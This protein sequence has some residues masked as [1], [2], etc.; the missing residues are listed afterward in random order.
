MLVLHLL[1]VCSEDDSASGAVQGRSPPMKTI[2]TPASRPF[3]V[4]MVVLPEDID[5]QGIANNVAVVAWMNRVA[6]AHSTALGWDIAR[7]RREGAWFVVR[8]HEI[9]YLRSAALGDRLELRTW[10][11]FMKAA[12]A[13]RG[14]EIVRDDG[15]VI[16]RGLNVW[17][18]VDAATGRPRRMSEDMLRAF[19]PEDYR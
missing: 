1:N 13:Q 11:Q 7:Y 15:A 3:T 16:A 8:R 2:W 6:I 9:D 17:A 19:D 10:P 5:G 4:P 18:Y 14:H 12:T